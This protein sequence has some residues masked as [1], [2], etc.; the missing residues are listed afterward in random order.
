[1]QASTDWVPQYAVTGELLPPQDYRMWTFLT[2][3]FGMNYGPAA[4]AGMK[5]HDNVFI[6]PEVYRQFEATGV[7]PEHTMFVLEIR[8]PESEGSINHGGQF[9][10]DLVAIEAEI[11]D[12]KRF[13]GGWGFFSFDVDANGPIRPAAVIPQKAS[14]YS[15][16][17][18]NAAVEN[19]F[20]QFYP[21]LF[22]VAKAKGTVR[23]DFVGMPPT[24][25][26]LAAA[27]TASGW[28][29][30]ERLLVDSA[31]RWPDAMVV[32]EGTVNLIAYRLLG[33]GKQA[34]AIA[35]F[36]YVT[37]SFPAS[38]NAWDSLSETYEAAGR[39]DEARRATAEGLRLLPADQTL[40]GQRRQAVERSLNDRAA[41]LSSRPPAR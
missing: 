33:A 15:C 28:S 2:S 12:S 26:E 27:A 14:C 29:T 30:A 24:S 7:W 9:Q 32:R 19:T 41:R 36:Q 5:Q 31:K 35:A 22:Q 39:L 6:R 23:A 18:K 10:T 20:T 4:M 34:D 21:T 17:A 8:S 13:A 38:A 16:H 40:E 25:Q 1:M 11:K 37:R 3:G